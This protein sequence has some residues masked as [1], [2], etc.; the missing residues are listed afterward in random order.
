[1]YP[2]TCWRSA[3]P[4]RLEVCRVRQ[5]ERPTD[6][7]LR[8]LSSSLHWCL[9]HDRSCHLVLIGS[10]HYLV[11]DWVLLSAW[12]VHLARISSPPPSSLTLGFLF[13]FPSSSK[14][15]LFLTHISVLKTVEFSQHPLG[16]IKSRRMLL[17]HRPN[18]EREKILKHHGCF[19]CEDRVNNF[20]K[21][22]LISPPASPA[23]WSKTDIKTWNSFICTTESSFSTKAKPSYPVLLQQIYKANEQ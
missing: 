8:P 1:M 5:A 9:Q 13:L 4:V 6:W 12:H 22:V 10:S 21:T 14:A 19:F 18:C 7:L 15:S 20:L 3:F 17:K 11:K 2:E 23:V 16:S